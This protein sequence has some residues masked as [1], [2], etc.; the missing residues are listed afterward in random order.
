MGV[1]RAR[2]APGT[3][4]WRCAARRTWVSG[5]TW[6]SH[7]V[8]SASASATAARP[9]STSWP[10][11]M[12]VPPPPPKAPQQPPPSMLGR[13]DSESRDFFSCVP[14]KGALLRGI[15][16]VGYANA[17]IVSQGLRAN[18]PGGAFTTW[19]AA[20]PYTYF[21]V[22]PSVPLVGGGRSQ[23]RPPDTWESLCSRVFSCLPT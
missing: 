8:P 17:K 23:D 13:Q 4:S 15:P 1:G 3:P 7:N 19:P 16:G 6:V 14:A 10:L 11:I 21:L 9:R 5:H 12:L 22:S 18:S 2:P 20:E